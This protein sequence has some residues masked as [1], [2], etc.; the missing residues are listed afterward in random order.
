MTITISKTYLKV[1]GVL[2]TSLVA[3][4]GVHLLTDDNRDVATLSAV[5]ESSI[6]LP[7][8][9]APGTTRVVVQGTGPTPDAA[10]QGALDAALK[11]CIA[12]ELDSAEWAARG[13]TLLAAL[14][15]DGKGVL[16]GWRELSTG[17]E[18]HFANKIYRS[19]VSVDVDV[20][21]LRERLRPPGQKAC[22]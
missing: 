9:L 3:P 15:H 10:F 6:A 20:D 18:R 12:A 11:R 7:D 17:S 21:A 2:F 4:L 19:E 14:R 5:P 1:I 16:R 13:Q 22:R 8:E